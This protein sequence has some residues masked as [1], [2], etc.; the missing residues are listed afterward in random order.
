VRGRLVLEARWK[1]G[2]VK[3]CRVHSRGGGNREL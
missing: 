2:P 1:R 3:G